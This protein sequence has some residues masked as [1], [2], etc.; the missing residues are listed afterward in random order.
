MRYSVSDLSDLI[1]DRR[2]I[3]P[4]DL[5]DRVVQRDIIERLLQN[6][7][8]APSHGMTQ[9]WRFTVFSGDG[10]KRLSEFL[11]NEY[12]RITAPEKFMQRKYDNHVQ[13]PL[14]ASVTIALGMARDASGKISELDEMLATACAVQNMHLTCTAYGLGAFWATGAALT[15]EGMR[16][17][18]GLGAQDRCLGLFFVGYPSIPW[19]K[20][21]RKPYPDLV[22]WVEQ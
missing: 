3:Y 19:P 9:P 10:R 18:L 13:R 11:G 20:G 14:Q 8:W 17:F 2:T 15:G 4:K 22:R 16:D 5:T 7:T 12:T 1:R 21:Y 6:A